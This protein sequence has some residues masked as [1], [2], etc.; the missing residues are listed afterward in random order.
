MH[1]LLWGFEQIWVLKKLTLAI[2]C[3]L[4]QWGWEQILGVSHSLVFDDSP[5]FLKTSLVS[6]IIC[7]REGSPG[8]NWFFK[9]L[10]SVTFGNQG[11]VF[12]LL[13]SP[14][15]PLFPGP[16]SGQ[17]WGKVNSCSSLHNIHLHSRCSRCLMIG[18]TSHGLTV[19]LFIDSLGVF[20]NR[21]MF[22]SFLHK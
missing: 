15:V 22:F 4:I 17:D 6:G 13:V 12:C 9:G 19:V 18:F 8:I 20:T 1:R 10:L 7:F 5:H 21:G 14:D 2:N 11:L 16:F 3:L